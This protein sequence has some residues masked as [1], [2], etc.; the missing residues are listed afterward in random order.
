[1]KMV[2]GKLNGNRSFNPATAKASNGLT[3]VKNVIASPVFNSGENFTQ[4]GTNLGTT[5]YIDAFQ[6]GNFWSTVA[7][8]S[9]YH[10]FL[11]A[12]VILPTQT[13]NVPPALGKVMS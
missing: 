12:P 5:Q 2:Y 11:G 4:G 6:R 7:S 1:I 9:S 13:I 8:H 10:V 3:I